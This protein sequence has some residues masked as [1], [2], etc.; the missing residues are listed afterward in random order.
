LK[1]ISRLR[2]A[3]RRRTRR[4]PGCDNASRSCASACAACSS[5]LICLSVR[6]GSL[7]GSTVGRTGCSSSASLR[8]DERLLASAPVMLRTVMG[9]SIPAPTQ[10]CRAHVQA[11]ARSTY[12]HRVWPCH[13]GRDEKCAHDERERGVCAHSEFILTRS[14]ATDKITDFVTRRKGGPG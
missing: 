7:S 10:S 6:R 8:A 1:A 14:C 11:L 2:C 3:P 4:P 12:T 13:G 5:H 9:L